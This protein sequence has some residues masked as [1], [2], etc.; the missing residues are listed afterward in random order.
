[1]SKP[2][3][4]QFGSPDGVTV[5]LLIG[6]VASC[7]RC[8]RPIFRD[9]AFLADDEEPDSEGEPESVA[10]QVARGW[11]RLSGPEWVDKGC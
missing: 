10:G 9:H 3:F 4:T 5:G 6:D 1:M 11:S 7:A 2:R 8:F